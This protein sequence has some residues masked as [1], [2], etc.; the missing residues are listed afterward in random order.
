MAEGIQRFVFLYADKR[1]LCDFFTH[2]GLP[3][4]CLMLSYVLQGLGGIK[5]SLLSCTI[6]KMKWLNI[7]NTHN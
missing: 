4:S 6:H 2:L 3:W 1:G 5:Q 7:D